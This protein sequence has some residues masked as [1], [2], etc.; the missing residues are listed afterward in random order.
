MNLFIYLIVTKYVFQI[1]YFFICLTI[2]QL[3]NGWDEVV[4]RQALLAQWRLDQRRALGM[5]DTVPIDVLKSIAPSL[6]KSNDSD[7]ANKG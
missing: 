4:A 2:T 3:S 1:I 6:K 7:K 5:N